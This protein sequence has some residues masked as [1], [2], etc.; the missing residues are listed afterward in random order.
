M[1]PVIFVSQ[2][3]NICDAFATVDIT[4]IT[5]LRNVVFGMCFQT[6]GFQFPVW[7]FVP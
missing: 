3:H 2:V 5:F 1:F 6:M 7:V 4:V